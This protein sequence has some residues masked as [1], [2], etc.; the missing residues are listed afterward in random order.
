MA[1]PPEAQGEAA[2]TVKVE[3]PA[4]ERK[5]MK[6]K[7]K[8][9]RELGTAPVVAR[10]MPRAQVSREEPG[11]GFTLAAAASLLA[12]A[13]LTYFLVVQVMAHVL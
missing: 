8:A 9:A 3:E 4:G 5:L 7:G 6:L 12:M 13:A 10:T 11:V 1:V 2:D